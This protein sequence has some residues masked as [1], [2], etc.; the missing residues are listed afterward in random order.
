MSVLSAVSRCHLPCCS[1][2]LLPVT[3][4]AHLRP[5]SSLSVPLLFSDREI[6]KQE[7][8]INKPSLLL[9]ALVAST[10]SDFDQRA[11]REVEAPS[12]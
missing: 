12:Q 8:V 6:H 3:L 1:M 4:S 10:D 9:V 7:E 11:F 2:C 5:G